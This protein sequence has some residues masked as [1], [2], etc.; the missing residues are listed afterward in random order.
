MISSSLNFN[1]RDELNIRLPIKDQWS[2]Y[3]I[4][5]ISSS[6]ASYFFNFIGL[7][8]KVSL[9]GKILYLNSNEINSL[10]ERTISELP[11]SEKT[12]SFLTTLFNEIFKQNEVLE[13]EITLILNLSGELDDLLKEADR[14][15]KTTYP[16]SANEIEFTFSAEAKVRQTILESHETNQT[17]QKGLI[18]LHQQL[19]LPLVRKAKK[20]IQVNAKH[21]AAVSAA[22]K[23][24][25]LQAG[26]MA[27]L[28][29]EKNPVPNIRKTKSDKVLIYPSSY[30]VFK[31]GNAK[32]QEEEH[33]IDGLISLSMEHGTV[34]LFSF[35]D[36]SSDR[37]VKNLG[38]SDS[39]QRNNL[40]SS[41][42][43]AKPFIEG[44]LTFNDLLDHPQLY[45][46]VMQRIGLNSEKKAV[47]TA[48]FQF[49]DLHQNNLG[50]A[51]SASQENDLKDAS[52][53]FVLF[54]TDHA[55]SESNEIQTQKR[56]GNLET[57]IPLRSVLLACDWKDKPLN[58][59]TLKM[60]Q[61]SE[62]DRRVRQW[63]NRSDAPIRR[64]FNDP[65]KIDALLKKII[66]QEKYTL[67]YHRRQ[68]ENLTLKELRLLFGSDVSNLDDHREL[69]EAVQK[70]LS[71]SGWI[72]T[73]GIIKDLTSNSPSGQMQRKRIALQLF[74][75]L[76][77]KQRDALFE[78]QNQ[79]TEYLQNYACLRKIKKYSKECLNDLK[80]IIKSKSAPL[81]TVK[82]K[83]F[84]ERIALFQ[85]D[86]RLKNSADFMSLFR[87]LQTDLSAA[88][89]PTYFNLVK[90]MYPLLADAYELN[91]RVA[92][93]NKEIAGLSI[94]LFA[95]PI[96]EVIALARSRPPQ[97]TYEKTTCQ[98]ATDLEGRISGNK[99]GFT[100]FFGEW[101][102]SPVHPPLP[103]NLPLLLYTAK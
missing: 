11:Y 41:H 94:G 59:K 55:L 98:I 89:T 2:D 20:Q 4:G 56:K 67:S 35:S 65:Q 37:F 22:D 63:V 92:N 10:K 42:F 40:F 80:Q 38:S 103:D 8:K 99:K 29:S 32:S 12:K 17:I 50:I 19:I 96:E 72:K 3:N 61:D 34:G 71:T 24:K 27:I 25:A 85:K 86:D 9:A 100:A 39:L 26:L 15:F 43:D 84:L 45:H 97:T 36:Q 66:E 75:R 69:W 5:K 48:E 87:N 62:R 51:P 44:M 70:Q 82:R 101:D 18:S 6:S 14:I 47:L 79:R 73:N 21:L 93:Q 88:F 78:R 64:F 102:S 76:S 49:L 83:E 53:E 16:L 46:Q 57:I 58:V 13:E 30:A 91:L 33:L 1:S 68:G 90:A 95:K 54:D 81:S 23:G 74:P 28:E 52:W 31:K 77:W 7:S 60:L